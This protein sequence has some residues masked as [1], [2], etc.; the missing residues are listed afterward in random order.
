M[1]I[2]ER[3]GL[4]RIAKFET[5]HGPIETPT[6]LPVINPNIMNITPQ[7]MK[8]LGLQ[9]IITNSYIILRTP[10]LRERA[11]REGLHSLIGY[12]GPIMTDSGTF[13]SYVYGSIEF[14]NREVVDFQRRIGSDISTIL[15]V[16]TTPGT[17]KPEAEKAVIETYNRMLEVNDEEGIIAGPV[18]GGVYPDL[19]RKSAELM[20]STNAGY[21][22]IGGVVPL[23]ET[24]DYSTL[25]DIIINSKI[26]LSFNKPVHLF[27][28]GHPMFFAFSVYLGV[29]LFDSA[30]YIKYAKDDRLIYPDGTRDLAR[31]TEL[32]QW[33]PL[34]DRYTVKEIRDLDKERRSLEIA[35]HNLKA[36]FMEISEIKERIYEEG[37]AQYVAQKARSHPSL[38][39][40]YSRIMSYSNILEKYEDLSKKT[41]YFFYDSFSTRNPYVSRINR[42]TESYLSSNKKDTYAFTYRAWN[43]GYTNSE[44]VRDVYQKIDCNALISWSGTFVPAEL[45]NTYPIEQTVSSGFEPDPDFSRAKDLIAPFRVDMYKGEKFEGEQVRS[46]NLNKI[47]MVA[48]YQFGSGVGRMIFRDDVR[49]NVSKTG[50]IRGILSKEGRQIATMRNDGFFTLTYYGASLIHSQLKPPAMRVTVSKESAEYNAKGYSVFFKFILGSDENI[51]AKND[52][53]VVDEDDVLAAVGKA[54]V[55]GR[56]LREY[57]EGIAVKVHEGRDQS[58]K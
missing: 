39:K 52:V 56:E 20:N 3:D 53:L 43:P 1:K 21:H 27:G 8:P 34:Y 7:E 51:I 37:L 22:P 19:R 54:M 17:P 47:R 18:Q 49:I 15:D 35:R 11:L 25:V 31:I 6:V 30:S 42:F 4:A 24:Y 28:G 10:E 50:R 45:E 32:P 48:D 38:M 9:G 13:Q 46:F 26:N 44:F 36:I 5:P 57:T 12:D 40:A 14:N 41:A 16:F 58:E 2:E 33:S 55:S 23:L 29:D